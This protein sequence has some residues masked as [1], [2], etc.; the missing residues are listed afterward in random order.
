MLT[1]GAAIDGVEFGN[2]WYVCD[3]TPKNGWIIGHTASS[4]L[5][6]MGQ[7]VS[8]N[9]LAV[10]WYEHDPDEPEALGRGKPLSEG[11]SISILTNAGGRFQ[12]KFWK[13]NPAECLTVL[14]TNQ[15][16][17]VV[18]GPGIN[19]EWRCLARATIMTVR[20]TPV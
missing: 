6:L 12:V 5:R 19:H 16:D 11:R 15:G 20:W 4:P 1:N 17:F 3:E 14:L 9:R 18:W 10:K 8:A 13:G 2:A 7:D